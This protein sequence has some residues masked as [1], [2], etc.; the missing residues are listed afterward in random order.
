MANICYYE[1]RVKGSKKSAEIFFRMMPAYNDR[2]IEYENGTDD[3]YTIMICGDCKWSLDS[4]CRDDGN[5]SFNLDDIDEKDIEN[6]NIERDDYY[7]TIGRK[8]QI[9]HLEIQAYSW[10]SDSDFA[11]FEHYVNGKLIKQSWRTK[12]KPEFDWGTLEFVPVWKNVV[13]SD[14]VTEIRKK[15]F[16]RREDLRSIVI[17]DSVTTI[18][19]SAFQYCDNL[20]SVVLGNGI[21]TIGDSAFQR[22][23]N[24]QSI[25]IPDSVT[26]IGKGTF[27]GCKKL[28]DTN[29]MVIFRT[30][31]YDYFGKK[32][33]LTIPDSVTTIG[34]SAFQCCKNLQSINIPDSVT[35]I[36][37]SAFQYCDNLQSVVLGNGIT[38]IG[39]SAFYWC[40]NLK[41]IVIPDS[42][43]T[44]GKEAFEGVP[45]VCAPKIAME[46]FDTPALKRAAT[47]GYLQNHTRFTDPAIVEGYKKYAIGQ[48]KKLLPDIFQHDMATALAFYAEAKKITA[49][50]FEEEYLNPAKEANAEACVAFLLDWQN[51]KTASKK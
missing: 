33:K 47:L 14:G 2:Y 6:V 44:I 43:T 1:I 17:P 40:K 50:N 32:R 34:D 29:G 49:K 42:V 31:L 22:C 48:R 37:D 3:D 18:G 26:T 39:D 23:K 9:L 51:K 5:L 30:V 12:T 28:A 46:Y 13:I 21:T 20:Q 15:E 25:V 27:N 11:Q 4:Y 10:S 19:D 45:S 36:G 16:Y 38:T 7:L 41:N 24:L 8:S 35:T